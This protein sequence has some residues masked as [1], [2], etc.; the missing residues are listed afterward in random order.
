MEFWKI[1]TLMFATTIFAEA[2]LYHYQKREATKNLCDTVSNTLPVQCYCAASHTIDKER[3]ASCHLLKKDFHKDDKIWESFELL[4]DVN[5]LT[6]SNTRGIAIP[7]IPTNALKFMDKLM[8][9]NIKYGN[10]EKVE[11]YAFANLT[12]V[13][14]ITLSDNQIKVLE[15]HAF[16]NHR[17][18]SVIGLDSNQITE[19]NRDVFVELYS[20][21]R[22]FLTNNKITTIHDRAFVHLINLRELEMDRNALFSLNSETF[23][24][25]RNLQKLDLSSNSLEVIGDN[26]FLPLTN[27]KT[28]NLEENKIQMLDEKAFNGLGQLNVLNLAHN[29]LVSI[30]NV[31]TFEGM[32]SL[33]MLSLKSNQL[34]ELK[35]QV[36]SP[37]LKNFYGNTSNIDVEDNNLPC[38]CRLDWFMSLMNKTQNNYLK[39]AIE[40]LK[41]IPDTNLR[42]LWAK[43]EDTEKNTA[44]VFVE[45][46]ESQV[47]INDYE[48]YDDTQLNGKLFY[49]DIRDLANCTNTSYVPSRLP[50]SINVATT[51][52]QTT[53]A[54]ASPVAVT[55]STHTTDY[56]LLRSTQATPKVIVDETTKPKED[57]I[58]VPES[59]N[60]ETFTTVRLATVSAKPMEHNMDHD[61]ASDE[62]RPDK[63]K[64][65]SHRSIHE[66]PKE[67]PKN[68][69]N[70]ACSNVIS[71]TL[72][73]M[74]LC[75][76]LY[77]Y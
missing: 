10:I 43:T 38:D 18:L 35:P 63:V 25:L 47:Q 30:E 48:Y 1:I 67:T 11:A 61:M 29:K 57:K 44:Q 71:V 32:E 4:K 26:T 70:S 60:K 64:E 19:I 45:E 39:R 59:K 20:L 23:S 36:M 13:E 72:V 9:I 42:E 16:A 74:T 54:N 37:I 68:N 52:K 77:F 50:A 2:K 28:L 5:K 53:K 76:R 41:C 22:L 49:I 65:H 15:K 14:E 31:R 3:T 66:E 24:G 58:G 8:K 55:K 46:E 62:A 51:T 7:Y 12:I 34:T 27:L 75:F 6:I 69:H 17:D 73:S 21:E 56:E 40:N 33:T